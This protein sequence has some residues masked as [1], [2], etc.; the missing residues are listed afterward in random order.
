MK[1]SSPAF[2]HN[3]Y[4]PKKFTCEGEDVS[5]ALNLEGIPEGTKGLVLI[6]DDPDATAKTW[7]H[8]IVFDIPPASVIE[9][10]VIPGVQGENDFGRLD[11]GGPCPP[12]GTHRYFFK[13]Y[14]LD[15][16]LGLAEGID[17]A[18]LEKAM[19]GHILARAELI[20]FYQRGKR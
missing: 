19:E 14:A 2:S 16:I 11:Y 3:G 18:G 9:E 5:P 15:R 13:A 4:I 7:V 1:L 6:V 12:S 17:K 8:W 10:G 20:G